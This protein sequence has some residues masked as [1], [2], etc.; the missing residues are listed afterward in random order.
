MLIRKE[1][2]TEQFSY[3]RIAGVASLRYSSFYQISE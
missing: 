2:K 1:K 3:I